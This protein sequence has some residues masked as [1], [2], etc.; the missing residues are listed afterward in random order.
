[1]IHWTPY[2]LKL[3]FIKFPQ[4]KSTN[5]D[6]AVSRQFN[7][8]QREAPGQHWVQQ[9][10][11]R[12]H[13]ATAEGGI[14]D[15][16]LLLCKGFMESVIKYF[17]EMAKYMNN[18]LAE[19]IWHGIYKIYIGCLKKFLKLKLFPRILTECE[20]INLMCFIS[21]FQSWDEQASRSFRNPIII[22][23]S[24]LLASQS[25]ASDQSLWPMRG[26]GLALTSH[27]LNFSLF[28][29]YSWQAVTAAYNTAAVILLVEAAARAFPASAV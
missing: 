20:A 26:W 12:G 2:T 18:L 14:M 22:Q 11:V 25:E 8:S 21:L 4:S 24:W 28:L 19:Y 13:Q 29:L 16:F 6:M 7:W 5:Y 1:M 17:L 3:S 15:T 23:R 9:Q 10:L 27:H